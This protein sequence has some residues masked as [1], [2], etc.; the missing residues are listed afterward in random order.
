MMGTP[1]MGYSMVSAPL[2]RD[3]L[4]REASGWASKHQ[5]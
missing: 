1:V 4:D 5:E 2:F 3:Q